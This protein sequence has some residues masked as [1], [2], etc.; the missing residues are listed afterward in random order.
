MTQ[1]VDCGLPGAGMGSMQMGAGPF[2]TAVPDSIRVLGAK[3]ITAN[4]IRLTFAGVIGITNPFVPGDPTNPLSWTLTLL[5]PATGVIRL[6]QFVEVESASTL[7]ITFDG[8]LEQ[9]ATYRITYLNQVAQLTGCDRAEF[10]ALIIR[11]DAL[12]LDNRDSDGFLVD[13]ANPVLTRDVRGQGPEALGT[14]QQTDTG[15]LALDSGKAS[16]RKRLF[17][18]IT[19]SVG[20]FIH[21]QNYGATLEEGKLFRTG[22]AERL[23]AR[24]RAQCLREPEVVQCRV[25]LGR[26]ADNPDTL[27]VKV[28][29]IT[30]SG[31]PVD[32]VAPI[33]LP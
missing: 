7:I 25:F 22:L 1:L 6:V 24:V 12:Q 20:E 23:Q 33:V 4:Q 15:D 28:R 10:V 21:A 17:R 26:V 9:G 19:T 3:A 30:A 32:L 18:R 27:S 2:G 5:D 13:I 29:T 14:Y 8:V 11:P 16:L 31:E